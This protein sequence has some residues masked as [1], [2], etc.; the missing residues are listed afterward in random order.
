MLWKPSLNTD[1]RPL[2]GYV[3]SSWKPEHPLEVG[4]TVTRGTCRMV[5]IEK[6][7]VDC[8]Y[9]VLDQA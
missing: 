2:R 6:G 5:L 9:F 8:T 1:W 3:R 7:P 4:E